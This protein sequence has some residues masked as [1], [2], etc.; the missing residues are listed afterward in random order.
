MAGDPAVWAT[1][2]L[3]SDAMSDDSKILERARHAHRNRRWSEALA[4]FRQARSQATLEA[5]DLFLLADAAWWLGEVD[6][7]LTGYED[8]YRLMRGAGEDAEAARLALDIGF[9]WILRGELALGSGWTSRARRILGRTPESAAHG[10]A[11][12]F[13]ADEALGAADLD[14]AIELARR[15]QDL[16]ERFSDP[17]LGAIGLVRE[18]LAVIRKGEVARGLGMLDEAMLSVVAGEV[19]PDWAGNTYCQL[20]AVCHDLADIERAQQWTEATERW[21]DRFESAAMFAG[22]CRIHR[23]QLAAVKGDWERAQREAELVCEELADMN[24]FVVAE[25]HYELGEL[26]RLRGDLPAAE[27]AFG[28]AHQLGRDP[29]PGLAMVRLAQGRN[30][31]AVLGLEAAIAFGDLERAATA[32]D[33]LEEI[34]ARYATSGF[35]AAALHARGWVALSSGD[36]REAVKHLRDAQRRWRDLDAP[37][38]EARVRMLIAQARESLGDTDGAEYEMS[39]AEAV[40]DSLGATP[41]IDRVT[42][43]RGPGDLPSGL[44][45]REGEVLALVAA[46][47]TNRV[48]AEKLFIS[49]KTVARHLSNIYTKLGITS[50]T[51][52][53]AFAFEHQLVDPGSG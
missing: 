40:F 7:A 18:G 21:C 29:Q 27:D 31:A 42:K 15:V 1:H 10:Y 24:V 45:D 41:D 26:H 14:G 25:G 44:T 53:A 37:Y 12:A 39:A 47:H 49:D 16:A 30:Q 23:C 4:G 51:A 2:P 19:T 5:E 48:I 20:M 43:W 28:R 46:G 17:G 13:D 52:A 34:A 11:L 32:T 8:V 38:E 9:L 3:V 22:I 35:A 50:R 33:E 6:E 36:D